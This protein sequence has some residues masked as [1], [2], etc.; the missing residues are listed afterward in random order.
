M[1]TFGQRPALSI[2][3]PTVADVA[4]LEATLVSVL[5]NR[6][7]DCEIVVP[8][9]CRYDDP[10]NIGEEVRLIPA[11]PHADLT[12]CVNLGVSAARGRVIHVLAAGWR[13]TH[14]WAE[15][16]LARFDEDAGPAGG[17]AVV[18]VVPLVVSPEEPARV[19]SA[20]LRLTRGG[21][22][23]RLVPSARQARRD[24]PGFDPA[25]LA[26]S[27]PVLEAG[28][29][30]S[31]LLRAVPGGFAAACGDGWC[32]ADMSVLIEAVGGRVVVAGQ[33][34]VLAGAERSK[35][36]A[37]LRGLRAERVFW[38]SLAQRPAV[39]AVLRHAWEVVRAAV[40]EPLAAV[41]MLLGRALATV[42]FGDYFAHARSLRTIRRDWAEAENET[43]ATVRIDQPHPV[44]SGPRRRRGH[45]SP[46]RKTA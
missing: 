2:V 40:A 20:G 23:L 6:P 30:R 31:D 16:A 14:G 34:V 45:E 19:T 41:P 10:W 5:E 35:P 25:R 27:A 13:A 37:F 32:D 12:A 38:R 22:R 17:G 46:L 15:A 26:P 42:Q 9:A 44:R 3:V 7:A 21:R 29:W 8:F 43:A 36:G 4:G 1:S 39:S 33:S 28:F 24:A 18:A 11:P